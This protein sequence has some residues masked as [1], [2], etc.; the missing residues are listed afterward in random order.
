MG[1]R[2]R[3]QG[4]ERAGHPALL[5]AGA[6][7]CLCRGHTFLSPTTT[8]ALTGGTAVLWGDD[9]EQ[10]QLLRYNP[11][12]RPSVSSSNQSQGGAP[13]ANAGQ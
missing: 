4:A 1:S 2:G 9:S 10:V 13:P 3:A 6:H 7:V 12:T 11:V 5:G 8:A